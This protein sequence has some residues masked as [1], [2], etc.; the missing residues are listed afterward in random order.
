MTNKI[1]IRPIKKADNNTLSKI[2]RQVLTEHNANLEG[3]AFTDTETDY[4]YES[5]KAKKGAYFVALIINKIVGGSGIALLGKDFP[6][7]CELQ[8]MYLLPKARGL[9]ISNKLIDACFAFAQKQ[10][11][12]NC[13]LETFPTMKRA[14]AFYQK[15]G[16]KFIEKPLKKSCHT[17]C[18]I[19]M[20]KTF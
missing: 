19:Y 9:K 7:T 1:E 6:E 10:G 5:Y 17:A 18:H 14:H 15:Q 2:I 11:F 16:F 3:T 12:K 13:Y 4:L 8:K 20:Y